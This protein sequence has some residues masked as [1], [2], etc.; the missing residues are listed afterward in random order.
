MSALFLLILAGLIGGFA[1]GVQGPL[2]SL[3]SQRLGTLESIFI[4]HVG[5][6]LFAMV[7][8]LARRGGNL[9]E[10][11][12]VPWYALLAGGFGLIVIGAISYTIPR[13]GVAAALTVIIVG[14]LVIG[15]LLDH[16]GLL[17]AMPRPFT[18][19][20]AM[21]LLVLA[22]GVWLLVR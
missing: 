2:A 10:W 18:T 16:Y 15:A 4:V 6:A 8:L 1:V 12:Q 14:Q 20:R 17:G 5:G 7:P 21:G 11:Q 9:E 3:M 19:E 22:A 13:L